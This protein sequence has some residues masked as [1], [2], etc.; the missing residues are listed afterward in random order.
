MKEMATTAR[1]IR[2]SVRQKIFISA[3]GLS[4]STRPD[5]TAAKKQVVPVDESQLKSYLAASGVGSATTGAPRVTALCRSGTSQPG[6]PGRGVPFG[7]VTLKAG[8][9]ARFI[10]SLTG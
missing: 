2:T 7:S 3:T 1:R 6:G 10:T 5:R 8:V 9:V 4:P